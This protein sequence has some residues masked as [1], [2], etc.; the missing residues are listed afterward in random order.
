MNTG[1]GNGGGHSDP[2]S[3]EADEAGKRE[4]ERER[5]VYGRGVRTAL[6]NNATAYGFSISITAAYGLVSGTHQGSSWGT[7]LF[8]IGAVGGFLL[9]GGV[10]VS[11]FKRGSLREG[12]QVLTI[13][14]A[15]DVLAV[16]AAIAGAFGLSKISGL[17]GW[18]LTGFGT[19]TAYL[20]IGGFDV[21]LARWM[22]K[23]TA[24]G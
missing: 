16:A 7:V 14:G 21:V 20:V 11:W 2:K 18:P 5:T 22:A 1:Q 9:V 10:F 6:R 23:H 24:F 15:V 12:G 8:A 19:V 4:P 17:L 3:N 13:G